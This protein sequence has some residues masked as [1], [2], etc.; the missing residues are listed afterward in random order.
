[1]RWHEII[2]KLEVFAR[3]RCPK[4]RMSVHVCV[5]GALLPDDGR[6]RPC[7]HG[8]RPVRPVAHAGG[9]PMLVV[10]FRLSPL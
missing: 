9:L 4:Q 10:L 3:T 7:A 2:F 8:R 1:M 5:L 6:D